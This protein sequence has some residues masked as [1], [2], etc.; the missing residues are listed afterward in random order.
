MVRLNIEV[1]GNSESPWCFV[2]ILMPLAVGVIQLVCRIK[3]S[4]AV[5]RSV[6]LPQQVMIIRV[7]TSVA[8]NIM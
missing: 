7:G 8:S 5:R 1:L 6:W 4:P 2:C 3:K